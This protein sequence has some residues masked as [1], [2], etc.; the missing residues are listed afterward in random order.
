MCLLH[1]CKQSQAGSAREM[2]IKKK[3]KCKKNSNDREEHICRS[4]KN[5]PTCLLVPSFHPYFSRSRQVSWLVAGWLQHCSDLWLLLRSQAASPL[6]KLWWRSWAVIGRCFRSAI[7]L[8]GRA[9]AH[10]CI[11][12]CRQIGTKKTSIQT[13]VS[14][15]DDRMIE[16]TLFVH[17][18]NVGF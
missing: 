5:P 15:F 13:N 8:A 7:W 4:R 3:R 9:K 18:N 6:V 12:E 16:N 2:K 14:L 10:K 11:S 1:V 17:H